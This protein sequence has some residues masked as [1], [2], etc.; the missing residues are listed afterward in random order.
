MSICKYCGKEFE[1][2]ARGR[3]SLYCSSECRRSADRDNKRIK[4]VGKREKVCRQ[5]GKELPKNKS[6]YCSNICRSRYNAIK[7]GRS[8][9]HG[10]ITKTCQVCG[11]VFTVQRSYQITCSKKC[12]RI[13][14]QRKRDHYHRIIDYDIDLRK[15]AERDNNVCQICG[16]PVDWSDIEQRGIKLIYG[17][18]YP[19]MD[20]IIP[21]AK[22]GLHAW[23]NVQLAHRICNSLKKDK[24]NQER[25]F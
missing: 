15:L 21:W 20:H 24:D 22:G 16:K 6:Y 9:D 11:N 18:L 12:S 2:K 3:K 19:S 14:H 13:Y 1:Q 8:F 5:C 17:N 4:Y 10:L 23:D 7:Q 25:L